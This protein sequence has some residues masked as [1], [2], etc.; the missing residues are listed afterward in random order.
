MKAV[1]EFA[2]KCIHGSFLVSPVEGMEES[3]TVTV[4][5]TVVAASMGVLTGC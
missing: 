3:T 4:V 5:V 2:A 1:E